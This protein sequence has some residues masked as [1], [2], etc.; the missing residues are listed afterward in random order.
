MS[1]A[2]QVP[3]A[4]RSGV[5][6]RCPAE[7]LERIEA[8][9][10]SEIEAVYPPAEQRFA[11][12]EPM[13]PA[14][15][16]VVIMGQDPYHDDGQAH[17]LA[18]SVPPGFR[19]PPSLRNI[20]RELASD[21]GCVPPATG[22]LAGWARQG[23]LLLNAVLSV[24][25]HSPNSHR[26][27]GWERFTDACIQVVAAE[28][29]PKVFILW[30]AQAQEKRK[31]IDESRDLVIASVHPSPLSVSRGFYGSRPFSKAN[32]FLIDNGRPPVEWTRLQE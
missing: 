10:A 31:F 4:W 23:V 25:A 6:E 11:A 32:A 1:L 22:S 13:A 30:G 21:I 7:E 14:E 3:P 5:L 19:P 29:S 24:R 28:P 18:F 15:V 17:G 16:K 9:L 12:L 26:R 27:R 20:F 2:E 8:F